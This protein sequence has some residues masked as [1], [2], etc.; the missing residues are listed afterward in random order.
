MSTNTGEMSLLMLI[1]AVVCPVFT[2]LQSIIWRI[3]GLM[4]D[5]FLHLFS[6]FENYGTNSIYVYY[7]LLPIMVIPF[8]LTTANTYTHLYRFVRY[9]LPNQLFGFNFKI[10]VNVFEMDLMVPGY[11]VI[12]PFQDVTKQQQPNRL[13]IRLSPA[14]INPPIAVEI[15]CSISTSQ[16]ISHPFITLSRHTNQPHPFGSLE[17]QQPL[18]FNQQPTHLL[19]IQNIQIFTTTIKRNIINTTI[20]RTFCQSLI[21]VLSKN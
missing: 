15:I 10:S 13:L 14:V 21:L 11:V 8:H 6:F 1:E 17:M 3:F 16:H 7:C 4:I 20:C 12:I 19:T 5:M 18:M 9:R 2:T